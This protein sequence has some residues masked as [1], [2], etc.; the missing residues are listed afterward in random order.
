MMR[1]FF[2]TLIA[3]WLFF[4][5]HTQ[6]KVVGIIFDDSGSM[7]KIYQ[8]PT[9]G[10][11]ILA[12]TVDGRAG[13]DRLLTM[14]L[15]SYA[16][17]LEAYAERTGSFPP[18][19]D[20]STVEERTDLFGGV[21]NLLRR[22]QLLTRG[23]HQRTIATIAQNFR[24]KRGSGTP[25]GPIE[26]M[27]DA[28]AGSVRDG[29]DAY[30]I[31][32]SDGNYNDAESGPSLFVPQRLKA[33]YRQH[34]SRFTEGRQSSLR[35][36]YLFIKPE[37][38]NQREINEVRELLETL[39][40]QGVRD[41]L[42]E[43][44]N[45][46]PE[47]ADHGP[48]GGSHIVAGGDDLWTALRDIIARVSATD[49]S[50]Q[51]AYVQYGAR[52]ISFSSPL[53][54]SRVVVV[55]TAR[56][57]ASI[58]EISATTF[59]AKADAPRRITAQ[60]NGADERLGRLQMSGQVT[61]FWFPVALE[62]G[63]HSV[64]F[65]RPI[66]DDAF[67]LFETQAVTAVR[68][69]GEGGEEA[70]RGADGSYRL[71]RGKPYVVAAYMEDRWASGSIQAT[72]LDAFPDGLRF[73]L[74]LDG[75]SGRQDH[76]MDIDLAQHRSVH[77]WSP[78]APGDYL[79]RAQSHIPGFISP[80]S[81][82]VA[83]QVLD[84]AAALT[85]GPV[86][87]VADCPGC[88]P[89]MLKAQVL[90]NA[91]STLLGTFD[92]SSDAAIEGAVTLDA[93]NMPN[94]LRL[95][96]QNGQPIPAGTSVPLQP[97]ETLSLGIELSDTLSGA[98]L[99]DANQKITLRATPAGDWEGDPTEASFRVELSAAKM[100]LVLTHLSRERTPGTL[101]ALVVN[102]AELRKKRFAANFAM[103]DLA[104][105]P[106]PARIGQ[107]FSVDYHGI[108]AP[109][110][111]FDLR[112]SDPAT[113]TYGVDVTP[114]TSFWCLCYIG[115][116]N[117][118][119]GDEER[120]LTLS[121]RDHLGLQSDQTNLVM[122]FPVALTPM[123]MSCLLNLLILFLLILFARGVIALLM[124]RRFPHGSVLEVIEGSN[125][126]R[127]VPL[128]GSNY[129]WLR[130]WFALFTGNPDEQRTLE[131]LSLRA[132]RQGAILDIEKQTPR[133][134]LE[135]MGQ[136]FGEIKEYQSKLE[137]FRLIWGDRLESIDDSRL[138]MRLKLKSSD[139]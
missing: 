7:G 49:R 79:I 93:V 106:D 29:E 62:P 117:W 43:V 13:K 39:E 36:E 125:L 113:G 46:L 67:L 139:I 112:L 94:Y 11:Q 138:S 45:G 86:T 55:S 48:D 92:L 118:I 134:Y 26:V 135:R 137:E 101:D 119:L 120:M 56:G 6:A 57:G 59:Q 68:V 122:D 1:V 71:F 109:L 10:M 110:F 69:F 96:D 3:A 8:L 76:S 21:A 74:T 27:L 77:D 22:E 87:P 126:P 66:G 80:P 124:T 18:L 98:D 15:S 114:G 136:S 34:R 72:R 60:M 104:I 28:L 84:S 63:Q 30:L 83:I 14:S 70:P 75:P 88:G 20:I 31:I 32:V 53:S 50:G 95:V 121:Y 116:G 35:V 78:D 102:D 130:C 128:R 58:P 44:F 4:A 54:I 33:S 99:T 108:L 61:H 132:I 41:G 90:P 85:I 97:G 65:N 115:I 16:Q 127:Y 47:G 123:G 37:A 23:E 38:R 51:G 9:F 24:S 40:A 52:D 82:P 91:P 2:C 129:T 103:Q 73:D 131:G 64:E 105:A 25:Y 100:K 42:L 17:A 81:R 133:W 19:P 12:A 89:G 5:E 107:T 111:S